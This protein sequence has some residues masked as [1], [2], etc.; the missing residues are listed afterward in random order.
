MKFFNRMMGQSCNLPAGRYDAKY[1]YFNVTGFA[2]DYAAR[3]QRQPEVEPYESMG[4]ARSEGQL[5]HDPPRYRP[6]QFKTLRAEASKA[7]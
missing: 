3:F 7:K 6:K 2:A 4:S 1:R 5:Y